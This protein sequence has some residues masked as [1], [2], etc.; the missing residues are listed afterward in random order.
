[1]YHFAMLCRGCMALLS[2]QTLAF[3]SGKLYYDLVAEVWWFVLIAPFPDLSVVNDEPSSLQLQKRGRKD[4][5]VIRIEEL[6]PFPYAQVAQELK[7]F[8]PGGKAKQVAWVQ[9]EPSNAGAWSVTVLSLI[10]NNHV[11]CLTPGC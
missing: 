2:V 6:S 11:P 9:E 1:M 7:K 3:C 4:I 10:E 8:M 5:A